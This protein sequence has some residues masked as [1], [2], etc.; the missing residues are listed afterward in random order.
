[1]AGR[2]IKR[3]R[4]GD[5]CLGHKGTPSEIVGAEGE[6]NDTRRGVRKVEAQEVMPAGW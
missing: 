6:C 1:M 2:P 4:R 3:G 5:Q